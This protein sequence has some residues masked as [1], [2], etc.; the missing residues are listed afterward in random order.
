[1]SFLS[2]ITLFFRRNKRR[3]LI[4]SGVVSV[5]YLGT[6]Y[7]QNKLTEFQ[8][9]VKEENFTKE[10][11]K[12]RFHQ[13]QK[14]CY[15]TFI[16][17]VSVLNEPIL[18]ALPVE[19]IFKELQM[20]RL[21]KQ[22]IN[23]ESK[24]NGS[25]TILSED[26]PS[27]A[28]LSQLQLP[29]DLTITHDSTKKNKLELWAELK[30]TTITRFLSI[31][32]AQ[33]ILVVLIHIQLNILSR[34]SYLNSAIDLASKTQGIKLYS[35]E[36]VLKMEQEDTEGEKK[37]LSLTYYLMSKGYQIIVDDVLKVVNENFNEINVRK[38]LSVG[39]FFDMID[40]CIGGLDELNYVNLIGLAEENTS[41]GDEEE[42]E[43]K[44]EKFENLKKE[45]RSYIEADNT[46]E[47]LNSIVTQN[48]SSVRSNVSS[49]VSD[50]KLATFLIQLTK[51]IPYYN[52]DLQLELTDGLGDLSAS[53]YSNF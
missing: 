10:Q 22:L 49:S 15:M 52:G 29:Q 4:S 13:T 1:M 31:I 3:L 51:N 20:L 48:V 53:V 36:E 28:G 21:E 50:G 25:S 17:L 37:F 11:I 6:K 33:S 46:V 32:Y 2:S 42:T 7:L 12:R 8:E 26:F 35:D 27:E 30:I 23:N 34:K 5:L 45:L 43:Q 44:D 41:S 39:E 9:R 24:L 19:K 47:V 18:N 16:S 40:N 38:E 14:D